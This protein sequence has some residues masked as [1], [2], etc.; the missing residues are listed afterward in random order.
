MLGGA[1]VFAVRERLKAALIAA[2][3]PWCSRGEMPTG[4]G[5]AGGVRGTI[6]VS[7]SLQLARARPD[8]AACRTGRAGSKAPEVSS[9]G[10]LLR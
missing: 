10:G 3:C 4:G 9:A 7:A 2:G 6:C 8:P 5:R 1:A